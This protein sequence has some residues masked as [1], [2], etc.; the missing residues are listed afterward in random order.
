MAAKIISDNPFDHELAKQKSHFDNLNRDAQ[1][2]MLNF[3]SLPS[4]ER[5]QQLKRI[6]FQIRDLQKFITTP[7]QADIKAAGTRFSFENLK[8][9]FSIFMGR[10]QKFE[11]SIG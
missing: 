5:A 8:G 11:K 7:H 1:T 4:K 2:F 10:W 6:Q 3:A 9:S